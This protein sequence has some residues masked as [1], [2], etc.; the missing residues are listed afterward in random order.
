MKSWQT[1]HGR[2]DL[3]NVVMGYD[4]SKR[5]CTWVRLG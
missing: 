1:G 3:L 2:I 5:Q 4:D